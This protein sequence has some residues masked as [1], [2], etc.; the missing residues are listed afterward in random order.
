MSRV[1]EWKG[2]LQ[3][4]V[5]L[6]SGVLITIRKLHQRDFFPK[7][8]VAV[9]LQGDIK[10]GVDAA[11]W[12]SQNPDEVNSIEEY[13]LV[14]GVADPKV[15]RGPSTDDAMGTDDIVGDE[16]E[17]I[18]SSIAEFSGIDMESLAAV[19][20]FRGRE[21]GDPGPDGEVLRGDAA[22]VPGPGS[23]GLPDGPPVLE[24]VPGRDDK[25]AGAGEPGDGSAGSP[26]QH[27]S[28]VPIPYIG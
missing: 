16:R 1:A 10:S 20:K 12:M 27:V 21:L 24:A 26:S 9:A 18:I 4:Q 17:A 25:A 22:P 2:K 11:K 23:A 28:E 13:V 19:D 6:P 7:G 8:L 15:V 14:R 5:E 3:K